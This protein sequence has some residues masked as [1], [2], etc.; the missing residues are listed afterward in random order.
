M[1]M[2]MIIVMKDPPEGIV[3]GP[4]P[5]EEGAGHEENEP[6]DGEAEVHAIGGISGEVG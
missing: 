2:M 5:T 3:D 4:V 1:M 6:Q